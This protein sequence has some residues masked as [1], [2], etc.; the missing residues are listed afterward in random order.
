MGVEQASI[1]EPQLDFLEEVE[2]ESGI[3]A[4][5]CFQC[6]KCTNG[7]PVTFAM[8]YPPDKILRFVHLGLKDLALTGN[9]MWVCSAC[10]TCTT[11]CPNEIDI[12]GLMDYLKQRATREAVPLKDNAT[13]HFHRVFL[14]DIA[15]RGRVFE[16]GL[17]LRYMLA[18]G[19][20]R[21][22]LADGSWRRDM[23]LGLTMVRKGRLP[24][25]P[26]S[27]QAQSEVKALIHT[28]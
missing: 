12:A 10:E 1:I 28:C 16:A 6:C 27:V 11:R 21:A 2:R 15:R 9:T 19:Q 26:G 18:S 25:R 5:A 8:D 13:Y 7:C 3:K 24:L 14:K 20:W 22:R 23:R 17:L 4:S